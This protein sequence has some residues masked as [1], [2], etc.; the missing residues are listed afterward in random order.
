MMNKSDS[1][2]DF[3]ENKGLT[4]LEIF[5]NQKQDRFLLRGMR[6]WG[7]NVRFEKYN[8]DFT[9]EDI[10]TEDYF[11]TGTEALV[12]ELTKSGLKDYLEYVEQLIKERQNHGIEFYYHHRNNIR[13]MYCKHV[14]TL[15]IKNGRQA[16]RAGAMRKHELSE[17]E[18]DVIID[19]LNIAR[20]MAYKNAIAK[21]PYGGSKILVQCDPVG[22]DD[23]ESMGFLAYVTDRSRSISGPDMNVKPEMADIIHDRFT[24]NYT[25]G[26]K[27]SMGTSGAPTGYGEYLAI[28]EACDF[29][30]GSRDLSQRRIA[31]QG[32]GEVG[33][34]LAEYLLGDGARLFVSDVDMSKVNSLQQ[35]WGE[36]LVK[37]VKPDEVYTVDAD[38]FSPC[39]MGGVVTKERIG[40]FK[41][42]II[43][44]SAN[45]QLWANSKE[46]ELELA[47]DLA[48][49]GIL[50]VTDWAH[51]TGGV[52]CAWM[53][54]LYQEE[55]SF[56]KLKPRIEHICRDN[57]RELL[58]EAKKTGRT[59]T[60]LVYER[61]EDIVFSGAD[62]HESLDS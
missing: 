5:Y 57:F 54:W 18:I 30:Y 27:D 49:R 47:R 20:A 45:N 42:K 35:R 32:L 60:E 22:L 28:K 31:V 7:D 6:E 14:N 55:A 25:G 40:T 21:I 8:T 51:N 44:G 46:E 9:V 12:S 52:L 16:I 36:E 39:A 50:F 19:G 29:I 4:T 34:V 33:Y 43:I 59:P 41:F 62:F 58:E 38:V 13:S 48:D 17:P 23:L 61:V 11:A 26:R 24:R 3:M 37:Y 1:L 10:L 56:E 53:E 15:G 2:F